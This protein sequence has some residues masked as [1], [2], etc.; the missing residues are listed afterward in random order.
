MPMTDD[1]V[2]RKCNKCGKESKDKRGKCDCGGVFWTIQEY[3]NYHGKK[4]L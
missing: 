3:W 1:I 4:L 2:K